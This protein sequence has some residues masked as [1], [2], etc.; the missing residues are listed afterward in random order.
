MK[1]RQSHNPRGRRKKVKKAVLQTSVKNGSSAGRTARESSLFAAGIAGKYGFGR[2]NYLGLLALIFKQNGLK[3]PKQLAALTNAS[4][5]AWNIQLQ[6]QLRNL[7]HPESAP[8]ITKKQTIH[9][10]Q[11]LMVN[12]GYN[13]TEART[14]KDT[15]NPSPSSPTQ[16]QAP[17]EKPKKRGRKSKKELQ[18]ETE[19]SVKAGDQQSEK[20]ISHS[21]Q[22]TRPAVLN[23]VNKGSL[24]L[25]SRS[26]GHIAASAR[27]LGSSR[28]SQE[29]RGPVTGN[30][31]HHTSHHVNIHQQHVHLLHTK[32]SK[33]SHTQ[34][35]NHVEAIHRSSQ[36][37]QHF[38]EGK[39][40]SANLPGNG[41]TVHAGTTSS[42]EPTVLQA[43]KQ[44]WNETVQPPFISR[45]RQPYVFEGHDAG[46]DQ[47]AAASAAAV[48]S[49]RKLGEG[50]FSAEAA[51]ASIQFIQSLLVRNAGQDGSAMEV[52]QSPQIASEADLEWKPERSAARG[53]LTGNRLPLAINTARLTSSLPFAMHAQAQ[54]SSGKAATAWESAPG[55]QRVWRKPQNGQSTSAADQVPGQRQELEQVYAQAQARIEELALEQERA[56]TQTLIQE[57]AASQAQ[58]LA[59]AQAEELASVQGLELARAQERELARTQAE[60]RTKEQ[61]IAQEQIRTHEQIR[62]QAD[63]SM[64][65]LENASVQ[66]EMHELNVTE[67]AQQMQ[68]L[69]EQLHEGAEKGAENGPQALTGE[70]ENRRAQERRIRQEQHTAH[71][72][73]AESKS[74]PGIEQARAQEQDNTREQDHERVRLRTESA[75]RLM[76]SAREEGETEGHIQR[77][78]RVQNGV[79]AEVHRQPANLTHRESSAADQRGERRTNGRSEV[80]RDGK[81]ASARTVRPIVPVTDSSGQRPLLGSIAQL[82]AAQ[83]AEQG[84]PAFRPQER[85]S[86]F[87]HKKPGLARSAA[88]A[89]P[90]IQSNEWLLDRLV[91][92]QR[93]Q[94][95]DHSSIGST[96]INKNQAR[97]V[98]RGQSPVLGTAIRTKGT[99]V[100]LPGSLPVS[101]PRNV[102]MGLPKSIKAS[103]Q[104]GSQTSMME[105][106]AAPGTRRVFRKAAS[107]A[108]QADDIREMTGNKP[109]GAGTVINPQS[110]SSE[111][112]AKL[113]SSSLKELPGANPP[114]SGF[115]SAARAGVLI[116]GTERIFHSAA[117]SSQ[118]HSANEQ[119]VVRQEDKLAGEAPSK[120]PSADLASEISARVVGN[121]MTQIG[122]ILSAASSSNEEPVMRLITNG[123]SDGAAQSGRTASSIRNVAGQSMATVFRRRMVS[124][125][126]GENAIPVR[127]N[128]QIQLPDA[129]EAGT[130]SNGSLVSG[131]LAAA[132][133]AKITESSLKSIGPSLTPV[134]ANIGMLGSLQG[135]SSASKPTAAAVRVVWRERE[136]TGSQDQRTEMAEAAGSEGTA[137]TTSSAERTSEPSPASVTT[138]QASTVPAGTTGAQMTPV[139]LI[140][141]N[142]DRS[143]SG[144]I[145]PQ[146]RMGGLSR[147]NRSDRANGAGSSNVLFRPSGQSAANQAALVNRMVGRSR[148]EETTIR[149]E[150]EA[151]L[152]LQGRAGSGL[153]TQAQPARDAWRGAQVE[154]HQRRSA[155]GESERAQREGIGSWHQG[156]AIG[157]PSDAAERTAGAGAPEVMRAGEQP[158]AASQAAAGADASTTSARAARQPVSMTP[159]V[160]PPMLA[161]S[162]GARTAAPASMAAA[163]PAA[164]VHLLPARGT[165]SITQAAS[166]GR[167]AATAAG[168]QRSAG[169]VHG[170]SPSLAAASHTPL[171]QQVQRLLAAGASGD[172]I[173]QAVLPPIG[174]IATPARQDHLAS[175][176]APMEHKLAP[177]A[178]ANSALAEAPLEMDWLRAK[179]AADEAPPPAAT[180][181]QA[182]PEL[183]QEQLQ[184]LVKQIPQLDVA[185]IADKVFREIEKR[186]KFERQR[187]GL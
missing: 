73:E 50:P 9:Q 176:T 54:R 160:M 135:D 156:E 146:V 141:H 69:Q 107:T 7:Q 170:S 11:Q 155:G 10:I 124:E 149:A 26:I 35:A 4:D 117:D 120:Q 173:T 71:Q 122:S 91:H 37:L 163:S 77:Q 106:F 32:S 34:V 18:L 49:L 178:P 116:H 15:S 101:L 139:P 68:Q 126:E 158:A 84:L 48:R 8:L 70:R 65:E 80:S 187:R 112:S 177:S 138:V 72:Q 75:N 159:R 61:I 30:G 64:Q 87:V 161:S 45:V 89:A 76:Q 60:I 82:A 39:P 90:K 100:N 57:K 150:A 140:R 148:L 168:A 56:Q 20:P 53:F 171:P 182:P 151:K 172:G 41:Y 166:I 96:Y 81:E 31:H 162:A 143:P 129:K 38:Q 42:A 181:P 99:G 19:V 12:S 59:I 108:A 109:A 136:L 154:H 157:I 152:K 104:S 2:N 94:S 164:A 62:T 17:A 153:P 25:I 29:E 16:A 3:G 111:I 21:E 24:P 114:A 5:Q 137:D 127:S 113:S 110:L 184:E 128:G 167:A 28:R 1:S 145:H 52:P 102:S 55:S 95:S 125:A 6:L 14:G 134:A 119:A 46:D 179:M 79:L 27:M 183:S 88:E 67:L 33:I 47:A 93:Q 174:S 63:V 43:A 98:S 142:A 118:A 169:M 144:S 97:I 105:S 175:Q 66:E 51:P 186:M 58:D 36:W 185:K 121:S 86:V 85:A 147:T 130:G 22:R 133:A 23:H 123:V 83:A 78:H 131:H 103:A 115:Q 44:Y 92:K 165:G 180:A 74:L 40:A 132:I 13:T